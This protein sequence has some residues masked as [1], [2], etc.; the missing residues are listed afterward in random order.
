MRVLT[1]EIIGITRTKYF[2]LVT[3]SDLN[4]P[5]NY[6]AAFFPLM[7]IHYSAGVCAFFIGLMKDHHRSSEQ[8]RSNLL[9]R[10]TPLTYFWQVFCREEDGFFHLGLI[11]KKL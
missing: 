4:P 8:I 2:S 6:D 10:Q 9:Q 3:Y 7:D 5:R 11:G 1:F